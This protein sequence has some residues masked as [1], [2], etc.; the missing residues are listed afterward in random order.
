MTAAARTSNGALTVDQLVEVKR[1]ADSIG[2][3][4]HV[5]TALE[6]LDMLR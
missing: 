4:E 1:L 5:R 6:M 2:G 3:I